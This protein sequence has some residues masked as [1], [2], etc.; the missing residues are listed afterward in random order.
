MAE[1]ATISQVAQLAKEAVSGTPE[2]TNFDLLQAVGFGITPTLET[3]LI[4]PQGSKY[5]TQSVLGKDWSAVSISGDA[6]SYEDIHYL[7]QGILEVPTTTVN[8]HVFELSVTGPDTV[9]TFTLERGEQ[10]GS[11][12]YEVVAGMQMN[13]LS[14]AFSREAVTASGSA[15]GK[16]MTFFS[17]G[18]HATGQAVLTMHPLMP[19][20]VCVYYNPTYATL[21]T[22]K[23]T[24]VLSASWGISGRFNPLWVLDCALDS[25]VASVEGQPD[26]TIELTVEA[27]AA[28][29]AFLTDAR[30]A[31]KRF[32]SIDVD[33]G[34]IDTF[35]QS[36]TIDT[37]VTIS[38]FSEL[39]D[40]DGVYAYT[41]T[42]M[43]T[44]AP[45]AAAA[46]GVC[47]VTL[48]NGLAAL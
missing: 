9:S 44:I 1:R 27:D 17:T 33:G 48:D 15:F 20:D 34:T 46:P 16:K 24:R 30:A 36:V 40:Q 6:V 26:I 43:G 22:T 14:L 11:G 23:L 3:R 10:G 38:S 37:S 42:F 35:L 47:R 19:E 5:A 12:K 31:A 39:A 21:G 18:L 4:R 45:W 41:V 8:N 28:G 2:T 29:L 13:E 25:Y 32:I 7:L